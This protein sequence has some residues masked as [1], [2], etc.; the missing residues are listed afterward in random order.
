[1]GSFS[2]YWED[3]ILDYIFDKAS[4]TPPMIYLG[5]STA[6]PTDDGTSLAEPSGSAY[7]R[8]QT[9]AG[10]WNTASGGSLENASE[11]TFP[12]ATSPWGTMT[13]FAL[14]DAVI[15]GNMLAYGELN[16]SKL[17]G[18]GGI[19]KFAI[20]DLVLSLD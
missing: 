2:D 12:M 11:I 19:A 18:S 8:V 7:E 5:L 1:M 4:L 10:D 9:S 6:D 3:K 15:S 17:I 20:G 14:F 16:P 13:H